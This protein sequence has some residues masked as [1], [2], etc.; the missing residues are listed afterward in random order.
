MDKIS[1]PI[2]WSEGLCLGP[3][4][5][6]DAFLRTEELMRYRMSAINPF[7]YGVVKLT[8][9]QEM[10]AYHIFKISE[11]ECI[12]PDGLEL[13]YLY[14]VDKSLE[15]DLSK[16]QEQIQ[17]GPQKIYL[18]VPQG[19]QIGKAD[20]KY[21]RFREI[22]DELTKDM[23]I[24]G[25]A[26]EIPRYRA[27]MSLQV[28]STPP[29]E[30]ISIP[31]AIINVDKNKFELNP[32]TP[33]SLILEKGGLIYKLCE[34][35]SKLLKLKCDFLINHYK[36]SFSKED[37]YSNPTFHLINIIRQ[38][39]PNLDLV[40]N[41]PYISPYELYAK[42]VSVYSQVIC[43]DNNFVKEIIP[44]YDH[45][46]I[47]DI[48]TILK[49]MIFDHIEMEMP[50]NFSLYYFEKQQDYFRAILNTTLESD[51]LII[52]FR[53]IEHL[54]EDNFL[55][56]VDN[57]IICEKI[58]LSSMKEER[59]LGF[60]RKYIKA[61]KGLSLNKNIY[62]FSVNIRRDKISKNSEIVVFSYSNEF[63]SLEANSIV[64]YN[65]VIN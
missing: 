33:P 58:N 57:L 10:L 60:G 14:G 2:Q 63:Q 9:E 31:V 7:F 47:L 46:N 15:L 50:D 23:N 44:Q 20:V 24:G 40:L 4:Y 19:K 35:V 18:C 55:E 64:F 56:F 48:F 61:Q 6:Q 11:L 26:I 37:K 36:K 45:K 12:L 16:F 65:K 5:F 3:Q 52:G 54:S 34:D 28:A 32:F 29:S 39:I 27:N 53:K 21:A 1:S 13:N 17:K 62:L 30:F 49:R 43:V 25:S 51:E 22:P 41:L 38:I 42:M 59:S 8:I